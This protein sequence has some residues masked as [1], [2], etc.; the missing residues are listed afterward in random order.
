MPLQRLCLQILQ[1]KGLKY[2]SNND[3]IYGLLFSGSW[4]WEEYLFK[5]VLEKC[6]FKHPQN[7]SNKGGIYLFEN[8]TYKRYPDY[9]KEYFIFDAKYKNINN[10]NIDRNDMHQI[11][12]YMHIFI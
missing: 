1:H 2:G 4:L 3:K 8:N 10:D 9:I 6:E 11:I 12:S 5:L 7:K